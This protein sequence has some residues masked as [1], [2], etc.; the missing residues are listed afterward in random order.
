MF[1]VGDKVKL[2]D[3]LI[4][5]KKYGGISYVRAL[6]AFKNKTLIV[7]RCSPALTGNGEWSQLIQVERCPLALSIEM[8]E[9]VLEDD[10][11]KSEEKESDN[12]SFLDTAIS[13][14]RIEREK[15]INDLKH[16]LQEAKIKI[17]RLE[18]QNT[19]LTNLVD[20]LLERER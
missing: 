20:R 14:A 8:L 12:T 17:A 4:E 5:W 10:S 7:K 2:K 19:I 13:K 6:D 9:P 16:E 1:K 11:T 3:G 18:G 15:E